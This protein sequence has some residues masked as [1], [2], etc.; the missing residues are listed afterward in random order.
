MEDN[1]AGT[2]TLTEQEYLYWLFQV[3][4]M[5]AVIMRQLW[6]ACGSF[7]QIYNIEGKE[8]MEKGLISE[9]HALCFDQWKGR[10]KEAV[11]E[12]H[13]LSNRNVRFI[14]VLDQEYPKRLKHVYGNPMGLYVKGR[15]PSED[16]PTVAM[17]G[18]R[19]CSH[20]GRQVAEYLGSALSREGV[21]IISGL[22][23][24]IDGAAHYGALREGKDTYGVLGCGIHTCYPRDNYSL[25]RDMEH[26]GGI[27]TECRIKEAP[28]PKNFPMRNRIISGLS[29]V[30]IVVE[31]KEKSGS[32]ITVELGLEQGKE[33]YAVPGAI[34]EQ[35][36][37]GCNQL[38]KAG[39]GILTSPEDVLE[40]FQIKREKKLRV[41]EKN[42]NS[43]AK[44][45]K[46]LYS[47][48]DLRPKFIE[49]IIT[50]SGLSIGECMAL[51][52][53]LEIGGYIVQTTSHY[54]ARKI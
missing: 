24:G 41:H 34:T 47:C 44:K 22:A 35:L 49:Q 14:S 37:R 9:K 21:Q 52:L 1:K 38:I 17:V 26:M 2:G 48:L 8:L 46:M 19:M 51:L 16:R 54:Y 53:E 33:V 45:E 40:Y 11:E 43:L 4:V 50:E 39:A 12:Y 10:L 27:L 15:L 7:Q 29:D 36:S 28:R 30:I 3:P 23:A 31:A 20:Y 13:D 18:A 6:E 42:P 25:Y 32:L 5:G